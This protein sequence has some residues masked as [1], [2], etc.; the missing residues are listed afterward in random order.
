[1]SHGASVTLG[2]VFAGVRGP[3]AALVLAPAAAPGSQTSLDAAEVQTQVRVAGFEWANTQGAARILVAATARAPT[4]VPRPAARRPE[5]LVYARNIR[6]GEL[7]RAEDLRWSAEALGGPEALS[8]ADEAVGKAA[9]RPL[10]EGSA[11]LVS[12][13]AAPVMIHRDEIVS[14][15]FAAEGVSLV[16]QGKAQGEAVRGQT[17]EVVNTVSKKVIEAVC[18]GPGQAAVGPDV[19]QLRTTLGVAA[20]YATAAR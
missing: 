1:M 3:A 7:I 20:P 19:E 2:D 5:V 18:V 10:R 17:V 11:G 12:D 16:L 14:V 8:D 9:R 15:T 4:P 6:A 13:L